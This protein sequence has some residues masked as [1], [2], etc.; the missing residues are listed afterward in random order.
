[1]DI[2]KRL[3][4]GLTALAQDG[5]IAGV[6][7]RGAVWA[8]ALRLDQDAIVIRDRMLELGAITRAINDCNTFCPPLVISDSQVDDLLDIFATAAAGR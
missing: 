1:M 5:V 6:R 7:G 4:S 2:G 3:E 8:A